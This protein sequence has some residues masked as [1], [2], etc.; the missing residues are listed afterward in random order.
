MSLGVV[1]FTLARLELLTASNITGTCP[2][3]N[4]SLTIGSYFNRCKST[5][6]VF[7]C[8]LFISSTFFANRHFLLTL[9][10]RQHLST[11][12]LSPQLARVPPSREI[13]LS[14]WLAAGLL[15]HELTQ[16]GLL[17]PPLGSRYSPWTAC[18]G[19]V[20]MLMWL[21]Q[22]TDS[23]YATLHNK[24]PW[25]GNLRWPTAHLLN[26]FSCQRA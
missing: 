12:S 22:V 18:E 8:W 20:T 26:T 11:A 9:N 14:W 4:P 1:Q 16:L 5:L 25:L 7:K 19:S 10:F 6:G 21:Q 2:H 23:V 17:S 13:I 15:L 24:K 3:K